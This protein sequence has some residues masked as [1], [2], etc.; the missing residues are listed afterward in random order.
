MKDLFDVTEQESGIVI[1][2]NGEAIIA[3]WEAAGLG[4]PR[5]DP[6]G[7]TLIGLPC[8]IEVIK[9]SHIDDIGTL[10]DLDKIIW[11]L[12]D[13][14]PTLPGTPGKVYIILADGSPYTVIAPDGW[15]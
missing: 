14:A 7:I 15:S 4:I 2:D 5:I 9:I 11:D 3:N 13:D 6:L 1:F 10:V 12:N 8:D